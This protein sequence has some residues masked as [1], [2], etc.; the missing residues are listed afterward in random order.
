[1]HCTLTENQNL[2]SSEVPWVWIS[3]TFMYRDLNLNVF[4]LSQSLRS[5]SRQGD[6]VLWFTSWLLGG[7][8]GGVLK[9][10]M[11]SRHIP[12]SV[13]T[14]APSNC[15]HLPGCKI[16]QDTGAWS[17]LAENWRPQLKVWGEIQLVWATSLTIIQDSQKMCWMSWW[18]FCTAD[19]LKMLQGQQHSAKLE[20][21]RP[22]TDTQE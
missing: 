10:H 7:F 2:P 19:L 3:E 18:A 21:M 16:F 13:N 22:Y 20:S 11:I 14:E 1:M 6:F 15:A 17:I 12:C 9:N 5:Q 4:P 8:L